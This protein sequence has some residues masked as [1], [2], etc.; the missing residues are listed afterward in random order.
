M[1]IVPAP[2]A[3]QL[4]QEGAVPVAEPGRTLRVHGDRALARG[5]CRHGPVQ[6]SDRGDQHRGSVPRLE[7]RYRA[8]VL[9]GWVCG[10]C[11]RVR[12]LY[13]R[14]CGL[15]LRVRGLYRRVCGLCLRVCGLCLRARQLRWRVFRRRAA[16]GGWT[17]WARAV[18]CRPRPVPPACPGALGHGLR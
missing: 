12:G 3:P 11:L 7:Q 13:R 1:S 10:L 15:C 6:V 14:V 16:G 18:A 2:S 8:A 5:Q 9:P 4:D 17:P